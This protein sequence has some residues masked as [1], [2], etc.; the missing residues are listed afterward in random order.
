M[1]IKNIRLFFMQIYKTD[2]LGH[3]IPLRPF[4]NLM[5]FYK[6]KTYYIFIFNLNSLNFDFF[7]DGKKIYNYG[8]LIQQE[9][10]FRLSLKGLLRNKETIGK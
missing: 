6:R 2:Y 1:F 8:S 10:V 4:S 7:I 5:T 3:N 9:L